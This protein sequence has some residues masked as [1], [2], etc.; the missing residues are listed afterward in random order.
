MGVAVEIQGLGKAFPHP[1]GISVPVL[2]DLD[3]TLNDREFTT[4]IGPSGSGKT[5]LLNVISGLEPAQAGTVT[6]CRGGLP[7]PLADVAVGRVFQEPRLLP[8]QTVYENVRLVLEGKPWPRERAEGR[9]REFLQLV[10]LWEYRDYYPRQL[11]GG[12][13]QRAAIARAFVIEP[14]LLLLDEPFSALDES[15]AH[16]LSLEL[17][18]YWEYSPTTVIFVTHNLFDAIRLSDRVLYLDRHTGRISREWAIALPR[19]RN[20][21]QPRVIGLYA[22]LMRTINEADPPG[23]IR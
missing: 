2:K 18:A 23:S 12:M 20:P 15:L 13:Q 10:K 4:L 7:V 8:W 16:E 1:N 6:L 3:L 21:S 22:E 17:Y 5:T 9:V 19:P 11:S 14:A